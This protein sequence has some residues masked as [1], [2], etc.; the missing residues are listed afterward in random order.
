MKQNI[1]NL[2]LTRW[3]II[4]VTLLPATINLLIFLYAYLK[5]QK[6]K[7]TL[8][9]SL[10]VLLMG[11]WQASDG[12]LKMSRNGETAHEWNS[13]GGVFILLIIAIGIQF[14]LCLS[15]RFNLKHFRLITIILY[16]PL[17]LFFVCISAGM[18]QYKIIR[19]D[20]LYWIANPEPTPVTL[21]IFIW[22][23]IGAIVLLGL[24]WKNYF[25]SRKDSLKSKQSLALALGMTLPV[26]GGLLFEVLYPLI[27]GR[28]S[29]PVATPL[30]SLFSLTSLVA[31]KKYRMLDYSPRQQW[32]KIIE[33]LTEGI[34]ILD[35]NNRIQ[36]ANEAFCALLGYEFNEIKGKTAYELFLTTE[37][38]KNTIKG[39][40]KERKQGVSSEY[41][42]LLKTKLGV[43]IDLLIKG[44][45]F[46]DDKDN[47]IGSIEIFTNIT[48]HK[49][50]TQTL[51]HNEK[52]LRQAQEVAHVGSWELNFTTKKSIWS[53][54]ACKMYGF[55]PSEKL[56]Q[57]FETWLRFIH[58]DDIE[59]VMQQVEKSKADLSDS[60]FRH[61]IVWSDGT[62]KH[63]HSVSKFELNNAGQPVGLFG[64]CH[65]IT[66]QIETERAL[67]ESEKNM[68]TFINESLMSIYIIDPATKKINYANRAISEMLGYSIDELKNMSPYDFVT[69]STENINERMSEVMRNKKINNGERQWRSKNGKVIHVLVNSFYHRHNG[70]D[71]IYVA[72]QDV[73][74]I[75]NVEQT[76]KLTNQELETFIYK[77]SHDL[78]GPLVSIMGL[79]NLSGI[80]IKDKAALEY[81][82]LI[83]DSTEKL[84]YVLKEL[85]KAIRIKGTESLSEEIRFKPVVN[86]ILSKLERTKGYSRLRII[87]NIVY[88]KKFASNRFILD[89]LLQNLIENGIKY[90]NPSCNNSFLKINIEEMDGGACI[91]IEDNGIGIDKNAI[92]RIFELYYRGTTESGGSGL[93]LYL[94][95]KA[96]EKLK[97]KI[98]VESTYGKGTK[99]TVFLGQTDT[100]ETPELYRAA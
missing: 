35:T 37:Q 47:I 58:P 68:R 39:L 42:M 76:L 49:K 99:F 92:D 8:F 62:I 54:E 40:L 30:L 78:R 48:E 11:L 64:I 27:L 7:T 67:D 84:D 65:D 69:H 55:S 83:G 96:V 94:V 36:Y 52:R 26:I 100:R 86:D 70:N 82:R 2:D 89:T 12:F 5:L 98:E 18:D 95:K 23:T 97:G 60:S 34:L 3:E 14:T 71:A 24:F 19:S 85:V 32:D 22:I 72:A 66:D 28:N 15:S 41:E 88:H 93:G 87:T 81:F 50:T 45:P 57:T 29:L 10:F 38:D 31:I 17:I 61:R 25:N 9:F 4:L 90:Q 20:T 59:T 91:S 1:F 44:T 13:I 46:I 80:E 43:P 77:I 73:T 74:E 6:S 33:S 79:V 63:I 53:E 16:L 21:S 56:D 75:K 51:K